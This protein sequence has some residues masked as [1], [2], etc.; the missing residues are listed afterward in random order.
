MT[1]WV[2]AGLNW[3]LFGVGYMG[4]KRSPYSIY[5]VVKVN[6]YVDGHICEPEPQE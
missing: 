4:K 3:T 1:K 2:P 6:W 5:P